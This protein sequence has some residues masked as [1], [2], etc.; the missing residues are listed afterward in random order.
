MSITGNLK[1]MELAELLQWLAG[2][3][4]TGTLVVEKGGITK[5]V[6]FK[7]GSILSTASTDR[8]EHLGA[9]LVSY[10]LITDQEL[11]QAIR[12]QESNKMLLGKI[13]TTIGAIS[14]SDLNRMLRLKAEESLYDVFGWG[15]GAFRFLDQQLPAE[16]MVPM[17]LDVA[18]IVLEGMHRVD[19]WKRMR[20]VIP[21]SDC[22]PVAVGAFD[23]KLMTEG[24][25]R[26]LAQV[27][28]DRSIAEICRMTYASEIRTCRILF[29]Q[30]QGGKLKFVRPRQPKQE[31]KPA[32]PT[33]EA[34]LAIGRKAAQDGEL[35]AALRYLRA[36]RAL[37]PENR[38]IAV[39]VETLEEAVRARVEHAGVGP[40]SVPLLA[41]SM[42]ELTKLRIS[43]QEGFLLTRFNGSYDLQSIVKISSL[44][45]LDVQVAV[46][47]L[48][49]AGH[50]RLEKR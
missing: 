9:F 39:D 41:R 4:K 2:A 45:P 20:E 17:S 19:E 21:S 16:S 24:A 13:L 33:A 11:T 28:D 29:K 30:A 6:F 27:N 10:G 49:Q 47:K 43:P 38:K 46:W 18:A 35:D 31:A 34:L 50:I 36:A 7:D 48:L 14:E 1:T 32:P 15:E 44:P 22:V 3:Q 5:Q 12:M 26:I 40:T 23:E 8:R 42:E 37:E 25:P